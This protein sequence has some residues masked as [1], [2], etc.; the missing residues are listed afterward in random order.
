M[1]RAA[2]ESFPKTIRR[3]DDFCWFNTRPVDE[4]IRDSVPNKLQPVSFAIGK[5]GEAV[6]RRVVELRRRNEIEAFQPYLL[7]TCR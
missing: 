5:Y 7:N 4:L 1:T 6:F 3:L 2:H